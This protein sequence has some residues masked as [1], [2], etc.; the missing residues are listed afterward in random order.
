MVV[1]TKQTPEL[2]KINV[3]RVVQ[4]LASKIKSAVSV[5]RKGKVLLAISGGIDTS[6]LAYLCCRAIGSDS[7]Y[8]L[9]LTHSNDEELQVK[10]GAILARQLRIRMRMID[11]TTPVETLAEMLRVPFHGEEA[12]L[13]RYQIMDRLR[14]MLVLDIAEQEGL[15]HLSAMNLTER[16]LGLGLL[17]GTFSPVPQP[18]AELH[19]TYIYEIA[20]YLDLPE[21]IRI[22][23]PSFELWRNP[24]DGS[25]PREV[26]REID[27]ILYLRKEKKLTPSKIKRAGFAPRFVSAV[28]K[29]LDEAKAAQ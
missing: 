20:D 14:M 11:I 15:A 21:Q 13:R 16:L 4:S 29:R 27:K 24:A 25:E 5:S 19:K 6:V 8:G 1:R 10:D 17:C 26:V 7:V 23:Q 3:T 28:L 2:P 18:L 12:A 9:Q 22:R